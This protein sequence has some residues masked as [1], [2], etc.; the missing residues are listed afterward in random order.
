MDTNIVDGLANINPDRLVRE[1][2]RALVG[3]ALSRGKVQIAVGC[4]ARMVISQKARVWV[5][6]KTNAWRTV[7][8]IPGTSTTG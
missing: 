6:G 3:K 4:K 1:V 7:P 8:R 2:M 5:G